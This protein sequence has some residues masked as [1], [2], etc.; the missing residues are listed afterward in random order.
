MYG[1]QGLCL[2]WAI[3]NAFKSKVLDPKVVLAQIAI[4]DKRDK[5]HSWSHFVNK[6]GID[7]NTF[8]KL[9]KKEYGIQLVK[10]KS[11]TNHGKY[12]LTFDFDDYYHTVAMVD[13]E[14][15][16]SRKNKEITSPTPGYPLVDVYKIRK[17]VFS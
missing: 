10:V 7:F 1:Q 14:V 8:K 11:Y 2:I 17:S 9:L 13:G 3:N 4:I 5:K 15:I 16:D 12:L 6:D